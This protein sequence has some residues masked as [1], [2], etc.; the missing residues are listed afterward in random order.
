MSIFPLLVGQVVLSSQPSGLALTSR[1]APAHFRRQ[2]AVFHLPL[3]YLSHVAPEMP[4][5]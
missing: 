2:G 3:S 1:P 5:G 4:L